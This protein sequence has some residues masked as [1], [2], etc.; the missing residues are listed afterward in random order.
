ML[1]LAGKTVTALDKLVCLEITC[2]PPAFATCGCWF[3]GWFMSSRLTFRELRERE[4]L[5]ILRWAPDRCVNDVKLG[6][7]RTGFT[8]TE[9]LPYQP[10]SPVAL[11]ERKLC[12]G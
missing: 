6:N 3:I 10:T 9:P 7:P 11:V 12:V 8:P 4:Y 1:R 5:S 2:A